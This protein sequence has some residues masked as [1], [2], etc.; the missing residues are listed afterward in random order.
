MSNNRRWKKKLNRCNRKARRAAERF[1]ALVEASRLA[2][3]VT[4]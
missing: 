3:E 2:N 1:L 4:S